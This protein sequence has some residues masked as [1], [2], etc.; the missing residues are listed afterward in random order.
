M[1]EVTVELKS[2]VYYLKLHLLLV[3][4]TCKYLNITLKCQNNYIDISMFFCPQLK[5]KESTFV[6]VDKN[7]KF[8][9][10]RVLKM[11]IQKLQR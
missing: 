3:V 7:K 9:A 10:E 6:H 11:E 8:G 5:D 1:N 4:Y 2:L